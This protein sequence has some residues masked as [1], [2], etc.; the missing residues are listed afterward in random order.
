VRTTDR[1]RSA[2]HVPTSGRERSHPP[3]AWLWRALLIVLVALRLP[4]LVQPAGGDQG[5]YRYAGERLFAGD[6]MY[7]DVWDQK[8]PAIALTYGLLGMIWPH[9]SVVPGADLGVAIGVAWLLVVLGRRRYTASIGYGA[10]A[11]FLLFGD[12]Y[13]QRLS[14]IY[15]RGQCE[16]FIALA[17]AASLVLLAHPRRQPRHLILAGIALA[18]AFWL[19]Y[20]AAAYALTLAVAAWAWPRDANPDRRA[21]AQDVTLIGAGFLA[22]TV[23]VLVYFASNRALTDLRLATIDY[24]LQYSNETYESVASAVF[25]VATLPIQRARLDMLWFLGGLGVL[26]VAA[27][28]T[29]DRPS[30]STLV[31]V[32]W[33]A[34][35]I[36]SIAINGR[37]GLPN[38]FVQAA[39]AMALVASAGLATLRTQRR[40]VRLGAAALLVASLWRV[41]SDTPVWGLRLA[42][43]PGLIDNVRYDLAHLRGRLDRETYL[44]RFKGKKH[45]A[46]ENEQLVRYIRQHTSAEDPVFVFGFSGGSVCWKSER[47]SSSRFYWSRP[48]IIEFASGVPGY[49]SAGLLADLR[50]RPP[51]VVALQ[52]EEWGSRDFFMS[53]DPLRSWLEAGYLLDWETPMFSVWRRKA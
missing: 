26:L 29:S 46:D 7:R 4:S 38:Y 5:L 49:G 28:A 23:A 24:N 21:A 45:D 19:K 12:P 33:S 53:R 34:A 1:I 43:I 13:L 32:A 37:R 8:P 14:G 2:A 27:K 30:R 17:V 31:A 10:A 48:V 11:I 36:V 47:V 52:K 44:K 15:V 6:V 16:P 51:A 3:R 35:A 20:N 40:P 25:Y 39:P 50:R 9:E 18:A 42:S 22:V 41:G